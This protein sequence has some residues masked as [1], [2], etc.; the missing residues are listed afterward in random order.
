MKK[1]I[2]LQK[3]KGFTLLET[4]VAIGILSLSIL[5]TFSVVSNSIQNSTVAKDQTTAFFLAQEGMEF[6][7]NIRDENAL[8]NINNG[9]TP[10][11][12]SLAN[13]NT[14]PCYFG[15]TCTIDSPLKTITVCSGGFGTCPNLSQ[16]P[17]TGVYGYTV[18]WSPTNF[19]R[20][21]QFTSISAYEVRV[22]IK[23]TWLTRGQTRT[24]TATET[25]LNRQ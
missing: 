25:L 4:L 1:V 6:I 5:A 9:S 11:L 17:V 18:G 19:K 22:S 10:W 23:M 7:K 21:I 12:T 20:E 24:F 13:S 8:H 14:D 15:K 2:Y 16:D 3:N